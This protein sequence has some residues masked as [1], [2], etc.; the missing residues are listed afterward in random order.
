MNKKE[1]LSLKV[2]A[3][4]KDHENGY[5]YSDYAVKVDEEAVSCRLFH[6]LVNKRL[7]DETFLEYQIR[8]HHIKNYIKSRGRMIWFSKNT[9]AIAN[10]RIANGMMKAA[11]EYGVSEETL[12]KGEDNLNQAKKLA[13]YSNL[14]TYSK[15]R[16]EEAKANQTV[17]PEEDEV[18]E[19]SGE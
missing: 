14:G 11:A 4:I 5:Q 2:D 3:E 6:T 1:A 7:P 17:K 12:R 9:E 18:E 8:R 19:N 16:V 10:Y 15:K 13:M